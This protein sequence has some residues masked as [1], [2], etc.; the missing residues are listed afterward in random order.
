MRTRPASAAA[1]TEE[2]GGER[3]SKTQLKQQAHELQTLGLA[4]AA[5]PEDRFAA[6]AMPER[7]REAIAE[8]RRTRSHEGRRR[9]M[10]YVGKCMRLA[11]PAPL[12]EAVAAYQLGS[13]RETLALHEVERW[14]DELIA[15]DGALDRWVQ[16]HPDTDLQRLR[17]LVR[18][19]RRDAQAAP[20]QRQS[21]AYRELFQFVKPVLASLQAQLPGAPDG[22]DDAQDDAAT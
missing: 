2:Y 13:A 15:D 17:S 18:A 11:D 12:R 14:R 10:Q 20:Q 1:D 19:A 4:L 3:P 6:I 8:Y 5:L 16:A 9:Q 7:L 21:R 22:A